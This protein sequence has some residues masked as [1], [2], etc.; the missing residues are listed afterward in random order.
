MLSFKDIARTAFRC[1]A[2]DC[3]GAVPSAE[4]AADDLRVSFKNVEELG[5]LLDEL[6]RLD[7]S[8]VTERWRERG[9]TVQLQVGRCLLCGARE[10]GRGVERLQNYQESLS[11][12]QSQVMSGTA[13]ANLVAS[14]Q[15]FYWTQ[16]LQE[17]LDGMWTLLHPA[18]KHLGKAEDIMAQ[19]LCA[20]GMYKEAVVHCERS[21]EV[22]SKLY[23]STDIILVNER[24]KLASVVQAA[25]DKE[26]A[27]MII[28]QAEPVLGAYTP[29]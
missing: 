9:V 4:A 13:N 5:R 22:L 8:L 16:E 10:D 15:L 23:P 6:P 29:C 3:P 27:K 17:V 1:Q 24:I 19:C 11:S 12:I 7:V 21:I 25:G 28:A 26:R 20:L 18:N 14:A 2:Q